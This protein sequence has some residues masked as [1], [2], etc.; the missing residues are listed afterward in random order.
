MAQ[1]QDSAGQ[2]GCD[3]EGF[4]HLCDSITILKLCKGG[5]MCELSGTL[6]K[7]A[8]VNNRVNFANSEIYEIVPS[9]PQ[10]K[11]CNNVYASG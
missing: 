5:E 11:L 7:M 1:R 8:P 2:V 3:L 4:F 6:K 9:T 10:Q